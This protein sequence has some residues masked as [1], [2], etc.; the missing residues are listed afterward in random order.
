MADHY[1]CNISKYIA[2]KFY[3][4]SAEWTD[5]SFWASAANFNF[6]REKKGI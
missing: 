4:G 6:I 1:A 5:A 3:Y 2:L